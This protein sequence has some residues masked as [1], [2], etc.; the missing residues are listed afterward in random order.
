MAG[1]EASGPGDERLPRPLGRYLVTRILGK[2]AMGVVYRAHD[3]VIDRQVAIK[4]VRADLLDPEGRQEFLDR[5]R[6]EVRAAGRC[7]HANIVAVYD[8]SDD[9]LAPYIV[10]ELVEGDTLQQRLRGGPAPAPAETVAI[11]T[12]VLD[13]LNYAHDQ[14]IIHRDVKPANIIMLP[15]G[16]IKLMDFGIARVGGTSMTQVGSMIG[17]LRYMAP[18][19]AAGQPVDHRADL[20]AAA[21]V[22]F[23]MLTGAP[24]FPGA[25]ATELLLRLTGPE[26]ADLSPLRGP[27]GGFAP[28]FRRALA[29]HRDDR[30]PSAAALAAAL[31]SAPEPGDDDATVIRPARREALKSEVIESAER[32]LATLVG[33][34]SKLLVQQAASNATDAGDLVTRIAD[35][36]PR[37]ADRRR[38]LA[39]SGQATATGTGATV[40]PSPAA[41][42]ATIPPEAIAAAQ[43]LLASFIGPIAKVVTRDAARGAGSLDQFRDKLLAQ[44]PKPAEQ[45]QFR[46]R[47]K[48][49]IS[50]RPRR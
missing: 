48:A 12:Q 39:A 19:Q 25:S 45:A 38:F 7:S 42:A 6:M 16:R 5:F 49:E 18:E 15:S 2:G 37:E 20:F 26:P 11:M 31:R 44:L 14:G 35:S 24:P 50:S 10:M 41:E 21:V 36:I 43:A 28:V 46:A 33:P 27:L 29:K 8:F 9:P 23:E 34:I 22:A 32:N 40:P 3:P 13:A 4:V 30:F 47:F 1:A 17:T